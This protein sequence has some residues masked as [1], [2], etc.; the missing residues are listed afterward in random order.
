VQQL[1]MHR[2]T[3]VSDSFLQTPRICELV[4]LRTSSS[5]RS[6][7]SLLSQALAVPDAVKEQYLEIKRFMQREYLGTLIELYK[8]MTI[9]YKKHPNDEAQASKGSLESR[10]ARTVFHSDGCPVLRVLLEGTLLSGGNA[11]YLKT[12][13]HFGGHELAQPTARPL[14]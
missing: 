12:C 11:G 4:R 9:V 13:M 10:F 1:P 3:F 6:L 2:S 5:S 7:P 8:Y 14:P